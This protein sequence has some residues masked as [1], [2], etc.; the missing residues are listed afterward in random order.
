MTTQSKGQWQPRKEP[1]SDEAN[2]EQIRL[3]DAQGEAFQHAL[4]Q[5]MRMDQSAPE[6]R[7]GDYL[8]G[9]AVEEAEGMWVPQ[10]GKLVWQGPDN[11]N[12]HIEVVV[13]DARDGRFLPGLDVR[14]T[15]LDSAGR[16]HGTHAQPFLWHPWLYHYGRNWQVPGPGTYTIRVHVE[17]PAF[18][19]HDKVNGKRYT[20]PIDV[21]FQNVQIKTGQKKD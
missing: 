9:C 1:S 19:R 5:M 18:P 21:D 12:A 17:P 16:E 4:N 11:E 20:D 14:V 6:K 7:A 3:A 13:R 10:G 2:Q 8:F 15:L